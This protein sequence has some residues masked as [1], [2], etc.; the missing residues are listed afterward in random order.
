MTPT[1]RVEHV[2]EQCPVGMPSDTKNREGTKNRRTKEVWRT[3]E[4]Y[5]PM[6]SWSCLRPELKPELEMTCHAFTPPPPPTLHNKLTPGQR[7]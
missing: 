7:C 5:D 6:E 4:V 1:Q 2:L 3:E